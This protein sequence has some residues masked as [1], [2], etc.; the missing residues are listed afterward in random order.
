[1]EIERTGEDCG[2][3]VAPNPSS[4][5]LSQTGGLPIKMEPETH[6]FFMSEKQVLLL[7][8]YMTASVWLEYKSLTVRNPDAQVGWWAANWVVL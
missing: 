5:S 4:A 2:E 8:I 1:V 6:H 7:L 3:K